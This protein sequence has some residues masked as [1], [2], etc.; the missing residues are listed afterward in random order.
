MWLHGR[1]CLVWGEVSYA[2]LL[3]KM[4]ALKGGRPIVIRFEE[5]IENPFGTARRLFRDLGLEPTELPKLRLKSKV[6]WK[7]WAIFR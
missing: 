6:S 2:S 5:M 4:L 1:S 3:R 7:S